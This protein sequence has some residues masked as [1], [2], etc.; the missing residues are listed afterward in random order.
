MAR[1]ETRVQKIVRLTADEFHSFGGGKLTSNNPIAQVLKDEPPSFA[2]GV[3]IE[4]V[5]RFVLAKRNAIESA[6]RQKSYPGDDARD[7]INNSDLLRPLSSKLLREIECLG[8][9]EIRRRLKKRCRPF[10]RLN[11]KTRD[12]LLYIP[13]NWVLGAARCLLDIRS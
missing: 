11:K 8:R 9:R 4:Q 5:V 12:V 13:S 7:Y 2:A 6:W 1:K 10:S 3:D